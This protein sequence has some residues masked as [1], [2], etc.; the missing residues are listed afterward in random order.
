M[1]T[2]T[3]NKQGLGIGYNTLSVSCSEKDIEKMAHKNFPYGSE[4][5]IGSRERSLYENRKEA[6][7]AGFNACHNSR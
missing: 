3:S 4:M 7:I 5:P 6:F 2:K 1:K